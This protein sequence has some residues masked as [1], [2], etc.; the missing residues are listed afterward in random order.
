MYMTVVPGRSMKDARSE[1]SSPCAHSGP[2]A[3]FTQTHWTAILQAQG[4]SPSA[5]EALDKLC[6][7][8]WPP[9]NAFIRRQWRQHSAQKAEDLTQEFFAEFIRKLPAME[10]SASKG[11]FRT[12][13]LACLTRFLCKD[14]ERSDSLKEVLVPPHELDLVVAANKPFPSTD[15]APERAFDLVWATALVEHALSLLQQEY[16]EAGKAA[17]LARLLPLLT[18]RAEDGRYEAIAG[19]LQTSQVALRVATHQ[20]RRRFG[21]LLRAEVA[22]TVQRLEDTDEELR[23]LLSL[24][25]VNGASPVIGS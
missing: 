15:C 16:L 2:N 24:W 6:R 11:R 12:Y 13:V 9:V 1:S 8:Y 20:L 10:L 21:E 19:E 18:D 5:D 14:W 23:Y 7:K 22:H 4:T 3:A 25:G 17:L